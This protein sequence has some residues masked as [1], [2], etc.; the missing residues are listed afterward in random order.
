MFNASLL[1]EKFL[2]KETQDKDKPHI[3]EAVS[4]R[5]SLPLSHGENLSQENFIIRG[6]TMHCTARMAAAMAEEFYING[7]LLNRLNNNAWVNLWNDSKNALDKE[8]FPD[9]WIAVFSDGAPLFTM[10]QIHPFLT[11]MEQCDAR[12]RSEYDRAITI[13]E[14]VF[15]QAGKIVSIDH[16]T[17]IAM[18]SGLMHDTGRTGL[19]MRMPSR[20]STFTFHMQPLSEQNAKH[21]RPHH[22]L[23]MSADYME[24]LHIAVNLGL[25]ANSARS[26]IIK[27]RKK[28]QTRLG[29]LSQS[30]QQIEN[31]FEFKYR[32]EK[33]DFLAI[34]KQTED[35]AS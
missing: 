9:N 20:T 21:V 23:D 26:E 35:L 15:K 16:D 25:H 32:P 12:N 6:K 14:D 17:T 28:A 34:I 2:I 30:I 22:L 7:P 27:R 8:T 18:V 11:V 4:N 5:I 29:Q 1:R 10:G 31:L 3:I 33:P 24:A 13:A 19:I